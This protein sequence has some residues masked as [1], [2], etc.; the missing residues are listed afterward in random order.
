ML[1]VAHPQVVALLEQGAFDAIAGLERGELLGILHR[2]AHGHALHEAIDVLVM[3]G[4]GLVLIAEAHDDAVNRVFVKRRGGFRILVAR[5]CRQQE[6][7]KECGGFGIRHQSS[8]GNIA[9]T[10]CAG[11]NSVAAEA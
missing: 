4:R 2:V 10:C 5:A 6:G 3:D 8:V 9:R 11:D 1:D 7:K